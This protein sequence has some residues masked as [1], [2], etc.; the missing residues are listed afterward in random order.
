MAVRLLEGLNQSLRESAGNRLVERMGR[1]DNAC[2]PVPAFPVK[3]YCRIVVVATRQ[4][5]GASTREAGVEDDHDTF[6]A[7]LGD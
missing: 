4:V 7:R 5:A 3:F 2:D 6:G 1:R